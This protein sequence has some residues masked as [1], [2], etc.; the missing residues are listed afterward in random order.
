MAPRLLTQKAMKRWSR[1][2]ILASA[3][4]LSGVTFVSTTPAFASD[5]CSIQ[6]RDEMRTDVM[7]GRRHIA[8][9]GWLQLATTGSQF[10]SLESAVVSSFNSVSKHDCESASQILENELGQ[11]A[12]D[13]LN[14]AEVRLELNKVDQDFHVD[15]IGTEFSVVDNLTNQKNLVSVD[16]TLD[17][18]EKNCPIISATT[19]RRYRDIMPGPV[20]W[21][22]NRAR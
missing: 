16:H 1:A 13:E 11:H 9:I 6:T 14:S 20:L 5:P 12:G 21:T 2:S 8:V 7:I 18:I 22:P 19:L 3:A 10:H 4:I 15:V 17:F